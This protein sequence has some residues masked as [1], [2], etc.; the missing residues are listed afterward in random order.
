MKYNP[1]SVEKK[2]QERWRSSGLYKAD[3]KSDEKPHYYN[4]VMFPYPSGD[5]LHIGHWYNYAPVD[6]WGRYMRMQGYNVFQPM[7]FDSF[8]LPAENYAIKTGIHPA[9]T[10]KVNIDKMKDQISAIGGMYDLDLDMKTS[11]PDYYKWTQWIFLKLYKKGLAYKKAAPVNWCDSCCTVLANE[12]VDNGRCERCKSEVR[13]KNLTQWFFKITDYAERLLDYSNLDWPEKTIAMQKH[14]IGKSEGIEIDF[15]LA[16]ADAHVTCYTTR[17]DTIH[18]VTFLVIAPEHPLV[19]KLLKGSEYE[20]EVRRVQAEISKQ[21]DIE[22]MAEEGNA[23]IG[24]FLGKYAINP[25]T[26]EKIPI[27]IANFVLMYGTGAVMADAHD[28]RDFEFAKKYDIPLKYVISPD[29]SERNPY[30]DEIAYTEDGIL[31]NA[32]E[33]SGMKNREA[34]SKI[35]DWLE[36]KSIGKRKTH[37]KLRDWLISRQRYWGA[38]IPIIYCQSCGEIPV[39]ESDLPVVHPHVENYMPKGK[40]PLADSAEFVNVNCPQCQQPAKREVDT[41]DTFVCS[42]WYFLRYLDA[43]NPDKAWSKELADKWMPVNMYVG[44]PEHACMHLLYARFIHKVMNELG[45]VESKEPFA[46]L[47]HQGMITKD[48]AKMSKSKGNVVSPDEFVDKYGSDV[49]RM[50]LMFMGPFTQGG[51][52][53]DKGITGVARF[54]DRFYKIIKNPIENPSAVEDMDKLIHETVKRT[55]DAIE[56]MHFNIVIAALMELVNTAMKKGLSEEQKNIAIRILAPFAPHL[57]EELWEITGNKGSVF[58]AS[59]PDYDP[60]MLESKTA[61]YAVQVNGKLR[62]TLELDKSIDKKSAIEKAKELEN[63][64]KFLKKG[65]LVKEIFVPNKIIAFVVKG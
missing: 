47:V 4:L 33:F 57:A 17:P 9:E 62:A 15:P 41:M 19:D 36:E 44:G 7:G 25:A 32:G 51:D 8:G 16:D 20:K 63:V 48:G 60:K 65:D 34:L 18:S 42:S 6:S 5:K 64:K 38:P 39:P 21:N 2:W 49:F 46:R 43:H 27:Y 35:A 40:S 22:R 52:W 12:Q 31:F 28:Q 14:W 53:N 55:K 56:K 13:R 1:K 45:L 61:T 23:K 58:D 37:Y 50:Y 3:L 59:W 10:T 26:G 29:G 54:V 11:S 24:A 30:E